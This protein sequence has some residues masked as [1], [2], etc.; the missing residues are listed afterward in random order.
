MALRLSGA[1]DVGALRAA[2]GDVVARH[3]SLRTVF[4]EDE[5]GP[6][7]RVL[8][9][10]AACPVLE[11]V[12]C[13]RD[14]LEG[15]LAEAA[16]H[17][18]DLSA[19]IP[20]RAR[21]FRLD[22]EEHV[23]M[24]V[25]H[26]IATDGW[27]MP[28]L[29]RD[30]AVAYAARTTGQEPAW[31]P[32]P[33]QYA[34]YTLWQREVLGSEDDPGSE[35]SRQLA[36]WAQAL[37]GLPE[38]LALPADRPRP[39]LPT[40]HGGTVE[41]EV[42]AELHARLA[43]LA[44]DNHATVFM[45]MQAAVATLLS[46]LGAGSDVPLGTPIAGR[47]DDAV[48][49]LVGFF[50][51]TL[52]LRTD[53]SG[54]P[55]FRELLARVRESDLAAYAHQ[56]LPFERLVE[57]VNPERSLSRH[58]LFQ[59]MLSFNNIVQE[60]VPEESVRIP[61]LTVTVEAASLAAAKFDL[62]F[63]FA[64]RFDADSGASGMDGFL[65]FATDLFDRDTA[66]TLASRLVRVLEAVTDDPD[67][68]IGTFEVLDATER[69]QVVSE[70]NDTAREVPRAS[71]PLL[72]QAQAATSPSR[73]ALLAGETELSYAELN[74][75]A[76]RLAHRLIGMGVGPE[77]LVAVVLPRSVELVVTLLAVL[78]AG[79]AYVPIDP[80]YPAERIAYMLDDANPVAVVTD[81]ATALPEWSG[82]VLPV[83]ETDVSGQ[84]EHNPSD[85]DR[86]VPLSLGHPAYV[87]YTSGSTGRPKG[88]VVEHRSL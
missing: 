75:R 27:S 42:P 88:V 28:L 62:V 32:L 57:V 45:V 12:S 82:P 66:T 20:V 40:G 64:E 13:D 77:R 17:A 8:P 79:G 49:D 41:F 76:N 69:Q 44:Q 68:G 59:V 71:L 72:F 3:E 9:V 24:L 35:I 55:S 48:E 50:V 51:N 37:A 47:T 81:S 87:I 73:A 11:V 84:P 23:L 74:T 39:A 33:V 6:Y 19:E 14:G 30:V 63:R 34:D 1:L 4:A 38:E 2:L 10:E 31:S 56:D 22:A 54:D 26:H 67:A 36:Y 43:R 29:G 60:D 85:A 5:A 52:V 7:Q 16:G 86:V 70:W 18:F 46:R 80:A 25:V 58:P 61:G 21:L 78:K 15:R 65:G 53:L 83:D